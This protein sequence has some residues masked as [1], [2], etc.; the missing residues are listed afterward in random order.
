MFG[1][2]TGAG[3]LRPIFVAR[4]QTSLAETL[5]VAQFPESPREQYLSIYLSIYLSLSLSLSLYIYIYIYIYVH[6][7][8]Y[9]YIYIHIHR[10]M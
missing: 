3:N 5:A 1:A 8:I 4:G 2:S 7:C 9:I 10:Y 6:I